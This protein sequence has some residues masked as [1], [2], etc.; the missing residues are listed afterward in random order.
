MLTLGGQIEFAQDSGVATEAGDM[1]GLAGADSPLKAT[2]D[3]PEEVQRAAE[4][5]GWSS[6]PLSHSR[7]LLGHRN[8]SDHEPLPWG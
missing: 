7:S 2:G 3:E 6:R 1:G 5:R 8:E 4:E